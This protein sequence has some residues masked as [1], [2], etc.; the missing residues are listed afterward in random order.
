MRVTQL[1]R[2]HWVGA[3]ATLFVA[4]TQSACTSLLGDFNS[5]NPDASS[6]DGGPGSSNPD[7][8]TMPPS[9]G[10]S[11][12]NDSGV[13]LGTACTTGTQCGS[14]FCADGVCCNNACAG[15]CE[16]CK[17]VGGQAG[18]CSPIAANTDPE[19]ECVMVPP[20]MPEAGAAPV[21][22]GSAAGGDAGDAGSLEGGVDAG[23]AGDAATSD[24]APIEAGPSLGY[25]PPDGGVTTDDTKCVGTC[26]GKGGTG[27]G[28]CAYPD[29][30]KVCGTQFCNTST[31]K[32]GFVCDKGGHCGLSLTDCTDYSCS[33]AT[34]TCGTSCSTQGDCLPTDY[35][36]GA[37]SQCRPKR[38]NGVSC[39]GPSECK[40]GFCDDTVCCDTD[41]SPTLVPGGNCNLTAAK[42]GTCS[43]SACGTGPCAV[44]YRDADSDGYGDPATTKVACASG[45]A[46]T[47]YVTN[48]ADCDDGDARVNP[49]QTG[50]FSS[51]SIGKGTFDYNCD[52]SL[53]KGIPEYPSYFDHTYCGYCGSP[54]STTPA[55]SISTYSCSTS[56]SGSQSTLGCSEYFGFR[57][58]ASTA[59]SQVA[60]LAVP[61]ICLNCVLSYC[62]TSPTQ[63]PNWQSDPGSGFA[64]SVGCGTSGTFIYCGTCSGS[65]GS[66]YSYNSSATQTCH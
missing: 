37:S 59:A 49:A 63:D 52:G 14:G 53:E 43:C 40:S 25:N 39:A 36:D 50:Y 44:Y 27:G 58:A 56:T 13:P 42:A 20:V 17:P 38:G 12:G 24:A 29:S 8:T 51:P 64:G 2:R 41:C 62:G 3:F 23:G 1:R 19:K 22:A 5:G 45:P 60:P 33:S 57:V 28:A 31:Q 48:S 6:G 7:A 26:D 15:T 35:C 55:C 10:S 46:P 4:F 32:G 65:T 11:P 54:Q 34:G 21:D 9:D 30:T 66:P 47:G 61:I 18:T 16:T